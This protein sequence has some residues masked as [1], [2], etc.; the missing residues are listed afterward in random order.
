[1]SKLELVFDGREAIGH[2]IDAKQLGKSLIGL[3]RI[4]SVAAFVV[5]HGRPP[6]SRERVVE[7]YIAAKQ[8]EAGSVHIPALIQDVPWLLPLFG[9]V[10]KSYGADFVKSFLTWLLLFRGGRKTE[11]QFHMDKM[12]EI[13]KE[14]NLSMNAAIA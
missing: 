14:N 4:V 12:I 7:V 5:L 11:A 1:M 3:D 8:P 6:K 10:F 2:V 9:E 13:F